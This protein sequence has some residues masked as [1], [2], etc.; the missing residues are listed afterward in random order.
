MYFLFFSY[1]ELTNSTCFIS[2]LVHTRKFM[3]FVHLSL[4]SRTYRHISNVLPCIGG[5]RVIIQDCLQVWLC[6]KIRA[7]EMHTIVLEN[8]QCRLNQCV[9]GV[10]VVQN[11][12]WNEYDEMS[13]SIKYILSFFAV[14]F[15]HFLLVCLFSYT[16][17][18][19]S[20]SAV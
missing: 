7:I 10:F 16:N 14:N 12:H 6:D 19:T 13:K 4:I 2:A 17:F 20:N 3:Y 15:T 1:S 18:T 9:L 8:I 11:G 5:K